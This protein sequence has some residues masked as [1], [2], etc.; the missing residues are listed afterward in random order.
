MN[1]RILIIISLFLIPLLTSPLSIIYPHL[2]LRGKQQL[3]PLPAWTAQGFLDKTYQ[4]Q[5]EQWASENFGLR[6][7]F[8]VTN[9]TLFYLLMQK[10]YAP[11][12]ETETWVGQ[13]RWLYTRGYVVD[14]LAPPMNQAALDV[15][16]QRLL[17]I[18]HALAKRG[19]IFLIHIT[20]S[21]V[22]LYPE[23][24]PQR[25]FLLGRYT[26]EKQYNSRYHQLI[27]MLDKY[28]LHRV[29]NAEYLRQQKQREP[30]QPL[31]PH[32]GIHWNSLGCYYG[33]THL[34]TTLQ[35]LMDRPLVMPMITDRTWDDTPTGDDKDLA[36]TLN[37]FPAPT[38]YHTQHISVA[39]DPASLQRHPVKPTMA[40]V[41]NSFNWSL[42]ELLTTI[43]FYYRLSFYFYLHR[44]H[45]VYRR[46]QPVKLTEN[47]SEPIA[48][49]IPGII[50]PH[51]IIILEL[52]ETAVSDLNN[53]HS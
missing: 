28:H 44:I 43:D 23:H 50:E 16:V 25:L 42:I 1:A 27:A 7:L 20:P 21:K 24:L 32:G 46:G 51:R 40:I 53:A 39:A 26:P 11:T 18:Q 12:P 36:A 47:P 48:R 6:A 8:I 30:D 49:T 31:F 38:Y 45:A 41:G 3:T 2:L 17:Y 10:V 19:K 5:L 34:I 14:Y 52:N 22:A 4:Q 29:D 35:A 15:Q 13:N 37:V 9:N 33:A